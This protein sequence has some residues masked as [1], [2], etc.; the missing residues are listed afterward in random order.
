MTDHNKAVKAEMKTGAESDEV[1]DMLVSSLLSEGELVFGGIG[2]DEPQAAKKR[3]AN[4][5]EKEEHATPRTDSTSMR[6]HHAW[7]HH[8]RWP[9]HPS[10]AFDAPPS[11]TDG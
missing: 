1:A 2:K 3:G 10:E 9:R 5:F 11:K 8:G 4:L 6:L 7:N